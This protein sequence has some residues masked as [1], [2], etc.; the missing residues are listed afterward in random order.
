MTLREFAFGK[1][2]G[3]PKDD[4]VLA[5]SCKGSPKPEDHPDSSRTTSSPAC[6]AKQEEPNVQLDLAGFQTDEQVVRLVRPDARG[7]AC[8]RCQAVDPSGSLDVETDKTDRKEVKRSYQIKSEML[9]KEV[10]S[11]EREAYRY[12]TKNGVVIIVTSVP[13]TYSN[14]R[15]VTLLLPD[16]SRLETG[17]INMQRTM[18]LEPPPTQ[19]AAPPSTHSPVLPSTEESGGGRLQEHTITENDELKGRGKPKQHEGRPVK[20]GE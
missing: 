10:E 9:A 14:Q 4:A 16:G 18:L 6:M 15:G 19:V 17:T 7:R 20:R 2:S 12:I 3:E 5:P 8:R 1:A 11:V 13:P